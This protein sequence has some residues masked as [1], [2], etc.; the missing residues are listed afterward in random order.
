MFNASDDV[1]IQIKNII[2]KQGNV[3]LEFT[4]FGNKKEDHL[5]DN[6]SSNMNSTNS[7]ELLGSHPTKSGLPA[8]IING[9]GIFSVNNGEI[10]NQK[11]FWDQHQ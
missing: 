3:I 1:S 7:N 2:I 4:T 11:L 10:M 8:K 6:I 9:V 5:E